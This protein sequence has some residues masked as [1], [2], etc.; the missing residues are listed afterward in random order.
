MSTSASPRVLVIVNPVSGQ[1]DFDESMSKIRTYLDESGADYEIRETQG[2]GD[3]LNWAKEAREFDLIA[4]GGGDGT[5]MEAMSGMVKNPEPV[6]LAQLPMGTANLLARALAIPANLEKA[7]EVAFEKGVIAPL[8]VGYLTTHDRYFAIVAGSGWDAELIE[9][10]D[11]EMKNKLGFFAYVFAGVKHLFDDKVSRV[12]IEIDGKRK[13]FRAHQ[14]MVINIGEIYGSGFAFGK[15]LSPHDG[16]LD[17]AIASTSSVWG[18]IKLLTRIVFRKFDGSSDLRYF[19][20]SHLKIEAN[21]PLKLEIDGEA[22][23]ETPFE[24]EVVPAGA[25]LIVSPDYIEAKGIE[26]EGSTPTAKN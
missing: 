12:R 15:D 19:S 6:P 11:R 8:D 9:D 16:K 10:A 4:V 26:T 2:E 7:F 14:V 21:P 20:A 25:R 24:V 3:A 17:L 13:R 23:G 18:L 5:V 22:I 1:A